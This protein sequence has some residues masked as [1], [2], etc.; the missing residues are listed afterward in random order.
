MKPNFK[1]FTG[2]AAVL[3]GGM[4]PLGASTVTYDFGDTSGGATPTGAAPWLEAVFTDTGLPA[5]TVQ[6]TVSAANL[7]GSEFLSCLYFNLNPALD[8]TGLSFLASGSTGLFTSPTAQAAANG[9]KA[10]PDGKFDFLINF[11]T[12]GDASTRFT[13]GDSITFTITGITGLTATDFDFLSAPAG[14]SG[15]YSSAAHIQGI[16]PN[17]LSGWINPTET[18]RN[19]A[20]RLPSVPDG[21]TTI[22]LLGASLVAVEGLRRKIQGRSSAR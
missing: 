2:I 15:P 19:N 5:N 21:A 4:L 10:G 18:I 16:D 7:T 17:S 13:G 1:S 6:L 8:P 22:S 14:G 20:D 11:T 3:L 12:T 9:F